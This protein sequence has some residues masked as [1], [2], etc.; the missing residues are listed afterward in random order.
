[1]RTQLVER[2][3]RNEKVRGSNPLTS[4]TLKVVY[5][6]ACIPSP[7]S[8]P[9]KVAVVRNRK[10]S[11]C[12]LGDGAK[13]EPEAVG[14]DRYDHAD[15]VISSPEAHHERIV[16]SDFTAPTAKCATILM[17]KEA[18]TALSRS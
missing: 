1:M 15:Q 5:N 7:S 8:P 9:Y 13:G 17:P 16:I 12:S 11:K 14:Y 3:V 10:E 2:L 4:T 6:N 18:I